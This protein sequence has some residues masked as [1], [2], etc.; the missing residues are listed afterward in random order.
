MAAKAAFWSDGFARY[1]AAA[2]YL[3]PEYIDKFKDYGI[4]SFFKGM[5]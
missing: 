1:A 4:G 5:E 3:D 2:L